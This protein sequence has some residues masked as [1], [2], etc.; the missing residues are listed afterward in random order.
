MTVR[1]TDLYLAAYLIALGFMLASTERAGKRVTF[2]FDVPTTDEESY[3]AAKHG[4][5]VG[6]KLVNALQFT[7]ALRNLKSVVHGD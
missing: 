2:V 4:Y 7:Q 6:T 3:L 5:Y 1:L